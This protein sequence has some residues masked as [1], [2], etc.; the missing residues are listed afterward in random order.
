MVDCLEII[1]T[2][3]REGYLSDLK[4]L[5]QR[6][7][8]G[9]PSEERLLQ[10]VNFIIKYHQMWQEVGNEDPFRQANT[11]RSRQPLY[12]DL[13]HTQDNLQITALDYLS[14]L[15][16]YMKLWAARKQENSP[17]ANWYKM[18]DEFAGIMKYT[19]RN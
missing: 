16:E 1:I 15:K 3:E 14:T 4:G 9:L 5:A 6:A 18:L 17:E 2:A 19:K 12:Q 11:F 10:V 13:E 8:F 7:Y